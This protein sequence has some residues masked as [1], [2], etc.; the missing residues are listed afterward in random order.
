MRILRNLISIESVN[1]RNQAI[2]TPN[3]Y[4][5][6]CIKRSAVCYRYREMII[7]GSWLL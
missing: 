2:F 6:S 1:N 4:N 3:P 7:L 5:L